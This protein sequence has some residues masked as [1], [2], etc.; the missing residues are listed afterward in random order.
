MRSIQNLHA[1]QRQNRLQTEVLNQN[2]AQSGPTNSPKTSPQELNL[3]T[4]PPLQGQHEAIQGAA[5]K[6]NEPK[7]QGSPRRRK[8]KNERQLNQRQFAQNKTQEISPISLGEQV[9]VFN[10]EEPSMIVL[11]VAYENSP[12]R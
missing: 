9:N 12:R 3:I 10:M 1:Q 6:Q 7:K 4:F 8:T 11:M 2:E 5:G